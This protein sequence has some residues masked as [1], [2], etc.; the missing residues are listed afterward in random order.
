MK[1]RIELSKPTDKVFGKVI[2][3]DSKR[4]DGITYIDRS[5]NRNSEIKRQ[6]NT[7]EFEGTFEVRQVGEEKTIVRI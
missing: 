1:L 3:L 2:Y 5:V 4:L 6:G 7:L